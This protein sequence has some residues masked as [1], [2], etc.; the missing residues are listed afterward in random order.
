MKVKYEGN[1]PKRADS[2]AAIYDLCANEMGTVSPGRTAVVSTG[3]KLSIPNG[4]VG[5]ICSS[6]GLAANK[7]VFVLN[8]PGIVNPGCEK[9]LEVILHNVGKFPLSYGHGDRIAQL[10]IV[11]AVLPHWERAE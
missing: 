7:G 4:Y 6:S 9:E 11:K 5:M 8:A 3:L 1:E 2:S 10:V